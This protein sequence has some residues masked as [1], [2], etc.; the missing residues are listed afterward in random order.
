MQ[1]SDV[2]TKNPVCA[3]PNTTLQQVGQMMVDCDCGGIPICD[4][5]S[6]R[7]IG[8]VTDRDI[9]CRVVAK[10]L[11]T[12]EQTAQSAMTTDLHTINADAKADDCLDL[13]HRYKVKRIPVVD[14]QN[15]IVGIVA[16]SDMVRKVVAQHPELSEEFEDALE[17]IYQPKASV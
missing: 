10:G 16:E 3:Q 7:L 6:N 15:R 2:M 1:V 4:P 14:E 5:Q 13:M 12:A 9:V 8:F 11:N 17:E